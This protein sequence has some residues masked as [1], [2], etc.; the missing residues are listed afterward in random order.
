MSRVVYQNAFP[1]PLAQKQY[2]NRILFYIMIGLWIW[3]FSPYDTVQF[4]R[5]ISSYAVYDA[6]RLECCR[7][8][9]LDSRGEDHL[10]GRGDDHLGG[11]GDDLLHARSDDRLDGMLATIV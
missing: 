10:D 6:N 1:A 11:C 2:F 3:T 8:D 7:D 5:L 9:R 4:E